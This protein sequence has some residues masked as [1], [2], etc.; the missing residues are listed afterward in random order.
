MKQCRLFLILLVI[1]QSN[2]EAHADVGDPQIRTDH[3]WYPGELA[4]SMFERLF[5]SQAETY[6]KVTGV[7]PTTDEQKALAAWLWRNT[8]YWHGEEG[9]E[10][11]WDKG[12]TKAEICAAESTGPACSHTG[13]AYAVRPT[14]NGSR[15]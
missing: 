4:C 8:H 7:R 5:A 6:Q 10:D 11:L 1:S 15:K 13:S 3:P 2:I 9:A 14:R 12:F